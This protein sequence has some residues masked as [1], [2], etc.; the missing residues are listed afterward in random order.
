MQRFHRFVTYA[1]ATVDI[2]TNATPRTMLGSAWWVAAL[3]AEN[4]P[5]MPIMPHRNRKSGFASLFPAKA[6]RV[7]T[8]E[9][10]KFINIFL[11]LGQL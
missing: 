9:A 7:T 2:A 5:A 1:L 3:V 4:L 6:A 11:A 8:I 10:Y